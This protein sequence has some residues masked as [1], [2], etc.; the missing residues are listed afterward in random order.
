[1]VEKGRP[2]RRIWRPDVRKDVDD[3]LAFHLEMRRRDF[4]K[5]GLADAAAREAADR[6]FG[7]RDAV[8]AA[9]RR[10]DEGV[11]RDKRRASMWM[12]LRQ[13]FSYAVRSL[14]RTPGFTLLALLTLTLGI[15]ANTAIFSLTYGLLLRPLPYADEGRLVFIWSSSAF[16]ER[17]AHTP[18]RLVDFREQLTSTEAVAGISQIS[19]N[20]TDTGEAE[21]VPAS[22]VSSSFFD[23]LGVRPLHGDVFHAGTT[24]TAVVVLSH[25]LWLRRFGGDPSIVGRSIAINRK[26]RRVAG[27]MPREFTWPVVT[28][29]QSGLDDGPELWIP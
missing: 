3:E 12:D 22:S 8:A 25:R 23:I 20:L 14:V 13:D 27:V 16:A 4:V 26:P 15:G 17:M 6:R 9:C 29:F 5:R 2:E 10:I 28:A 21:R 18:G 1:M 19:M 11:I 24:D 7:N